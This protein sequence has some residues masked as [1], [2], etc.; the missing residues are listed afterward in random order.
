MN[1]TPFHKF[2]LYS[3]PYHSSMKARKHK[4]YNVIFCLVKIEKKIIIK[5]DFSIQWLLLVFIHLI[6]IRNFHNNTYFLSLNSFS[7]YQW[8]FPLGTNYV[9]SYWSL[10]LLCCFEFLSQEISVIIEVIKNSLPILIVLMDCS[11]AISSENS[12]W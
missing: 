4:L 6:T 7:L 3:L 2:L 12:V 9:H 11:A 5:E 10:Y 1:K 8:R